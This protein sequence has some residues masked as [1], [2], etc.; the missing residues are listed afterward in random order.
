[1]KTGMG[2]GQVR[3]EAT[4][5]YVHRVAFF[6]THGVWPKEICHKCDNPP[7]CNPQHLV[8]GDRLFNVRDC[9]AKGR[10]PK[11]CGDG[12]GKAKLTWAQVRKIRALMLTVKV[13]RV[14]VMRQ[15]AKRLNM[16]VPAIQGVVYGK[17]WKEETR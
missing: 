1:M 7:C 3:F 9:I 5:H 11:R 14:R 15:T 6:L 8:N 10:Y 4:V 13:G 17:T 2:Y 16:S 12:L